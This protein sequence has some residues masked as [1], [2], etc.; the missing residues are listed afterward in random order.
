MKYSWTEP[1]HS[2]FASGAWEREKC[3]KV[4]LARGERA[5]AEPVDQL[6]H[7]GRRAGSDRHA[8]ANH[9]PRM[10]ADNRRAPSLTRGAMREGR[11]EDGRCP[12][13]D[14]RVAGWGTAKQASPERAASSRA[15]P[16][17]RSNPQRSA[18]LVGRQARAGWNRVCMSVRR[19]AVHAHRRVALDAETR[20]AW[21]TGR[22]LCPFRAVSRHR[23]RNRPGLWRAQ[24][25]P[26]RTLQA[27]RQEKTCAG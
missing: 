7:A 26:Q 24:A 6:V 10:S 25:I 23:R 22:G 18:A 21:P 1:R 12:A 17:D 13:R 15:G 4:V 16:V 11:G 20:C 9:P 27:P 14:S 3:A 5:P 19:R 2:S 8:N